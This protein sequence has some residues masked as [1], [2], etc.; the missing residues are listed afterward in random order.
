MSTNRPF[1]GVV[2]ALIIIVSWFLSLAY[3]L[4]KELSAFHWWIIPAMLLQTH[5]YTGLFITAHDAMHGVVAPGRKKLNH[6]IGGVAAALYAYNNYKKLL[7]KHHQHH[8]MVATVEDPDFHHGSFFRW[9]FKF[10]T[11]YI[12]WYQVVLMAFTYHGLLVFFD[13]PNVILF[14]MIPSILAT[15]QLFYFGTYLPHRGKPLPGNEHRSR[16]QPKNHI[17][18]FFSCYFFGYHY[19]H[20]YSPGT[21]WWMLWKEKENLQAKGL[22]K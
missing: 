15:L 17:W 5:L 20:H 2:I 12:T 19:E 13:K 9:Y 11:E 10:A 18:A 21:P 7:P 16:T 6:A 3:F 8:G 14:W 22:V 1:L 4:P